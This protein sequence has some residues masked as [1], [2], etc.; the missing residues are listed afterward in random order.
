MPVAAKRK[1]RRSRGRF[2][3]LR[4]SRRKE[5]IMKKNKSI[6]YQTGWAECDGCSSL[7]FTDGEVVTG[8]CILHQEIGHV[9][10][11]ANRY[12]VAFEGEGMKG[13]VDWRHCNKCGSLFFAG[14]PSKGVCPY[15]HGTHDDSQSGSYELIHTNFPMSLSGRP[16][17][18]WCKNCEQLFKPRSNDVT[19]CSRGGIH[20]SEGSGYYTVKA[21]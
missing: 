18:R 12:K 19:F 8:W 21:E 6:T 15:D 5:I 16:Y 1:S 10:T 11:G 3:Y 14:N 13:Q 17:W 20:V 9:C 7:V 4:T 2:G